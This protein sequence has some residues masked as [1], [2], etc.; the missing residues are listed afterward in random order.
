VTLYATAWPEREAAQLVSDTNGTGIMDGFT[1]RLYPAKPNFWGSRLPCSP[2]LM[3]AVAA[4]AIEFDIIVTHSLWNPIATFARRFLRKRN[5]AY[6]VMPHGML[7]PVVFKRGR[8]KKSAWALLW[9]RRNVEN[10]ALII[11]NTPAEERK[12]RLCGW[13]LPNLL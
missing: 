12:A 5:R 4:H 13:H 3:D 2:D 10:A 7:D 6:C 9:E 11:F 1:T 8:W